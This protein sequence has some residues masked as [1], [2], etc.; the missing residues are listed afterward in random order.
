MVHQ[1]FRN[2]WMNVFISL[3][4]ELNGYSDSKMIRLGVEN[5]LPGN[6]K[7]RSYDRALNLAK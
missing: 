1:G 6:K 4:R 2:L 3:Y 5:H 7:A